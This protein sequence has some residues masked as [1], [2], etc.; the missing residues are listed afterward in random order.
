LRLINFG[1]FS[2]YLSYYRNEWYVLR[3]KGVQT[4]RQIYEASECVRR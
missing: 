1:G 4:L 3:G 2:E